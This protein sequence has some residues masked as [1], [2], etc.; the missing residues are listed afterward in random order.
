[1]PSSPRQLRIGWSLAAL[2]LLAGAAPLLLADDAAKPTPEQIVEQAGLTRMGFLVILPDE[3]DIRT[4]AESL[5]EAKQRLV[6][7]AGV[8]GYLEKGIA[9]S[10]Q[11]LDQIDQAMQDASQRLA[12]NPRNNQWVAAYNSLLASRDQANEQIAD[13]R[14]QLAKLSSSRSNYIALALDLSDKAEAVA[15]KY[16]VLAKDAKLSDAIAQLSQPGHTPARLGPSGLFHDDLDFIRQ[17]KKDVV[18]AAIPVD[19]QNNVP[20]V[21]VELNDKVT[22][23]MVWDS[24]ATLVS[25]NYQT[26]A[27]IGLVPSDTDQTIQSTVADGRV[28]KDSLM[29][30][31]SIRIGAFTVH[32]VQCEVDPPDVKDSPNLLGDSFQSHFL[33]R[34]DMINDQLHLTPLVNEPTRI[35]PFQISPVPSGPKDQGTGRDP[36]NGSGSG[37]G[38]ELLDTMR[39][40]VK[41]KQDGAIVLKGKDRISTALAYAPP[42]RFKIVAMTDSTNI[43]IAY[44]AKQIIFNWDGNPDELRIDGGPAGGRRIS[45]AGRVPVNQWVEIGVE[46]D[47]DTL[48]L[49]VDGAERYSTRADFS[50]VHQRLSVFPA[51][52]SVVKVKSVVATKP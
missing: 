7:E 44:A 31:D 15:A 3:P 18:S 29:E 34:L 48:K 43:R 35:D 17:C 25:L 51:E 26:A 22:V 12:S 13:L 39:G 16:G 49:T 27:K 24:G 30:I 1:M 45:G 40:S 42:V 6:N 47:K 50:R 52:G 33:A 28:V 41:H 5:R 20:E 4:G 9:N 23:K 21:E 36:G 46:V 19:V 2:L 32:H 37:L 11:R 14:D 38:T 8:R 10:S